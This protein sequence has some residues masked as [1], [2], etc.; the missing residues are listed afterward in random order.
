MALRHGPPWVFVRTLNAALP[1]WTSLKCKLKS[2]TQDTGF[3]TMTGAG[4]SYT[5]DFTGQ[6]LDTWYAA[7]EL[8]SGGTLSA[9][10]W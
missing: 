10:T 9:N 3:V 4:T 1:T 8:F 5:Y 7:V 6:T 2:A